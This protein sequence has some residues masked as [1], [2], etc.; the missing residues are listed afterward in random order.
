MKYK[1]EKQQDGMFDVLCT[2]DDGLYARR[3]GFITGGHR[4]WLAERGLLNL[5]YFNTKRLAMNAIVNEFEKP[6]AV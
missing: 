6:L 5:G 2:K 3:I 1:T 4:T